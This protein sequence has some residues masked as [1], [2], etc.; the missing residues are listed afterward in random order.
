MLA[1]AA[2]VMLLA[3]PH[4]QSEATIRNAGSPASVVIAI[5][6][7]GSMGYRGPDGTHL[8]AGKAAARRFV[9]D[10]PAGSQVAVITADGAASGPG[11]LYDRKTVVRLIDEVGQSDG[12]V[13]VGQLLR[14]ALALLSGSEMERRMVV[15]VNDRTA[16]SWSDARPAAFARA[17][18]A[19]FYLLDAWSGED[20]NF[21]LGDV[22]LDR[23]STPV[24]VPVSVQTS[25]RC[26]QA[27][28]QVVVQELLGEDVVDQKGVDLPSADAVA[29]MEFTAESDTPGPLAGRLRIDREDPLAMDNV[30][31][32]ALAVGQAARMVVVRSAAG[33]AGDD[34][35]ARTMVSATPVVQAR[36]VDPARFERE[37]LGD[38]AIVLLANVSALPA[39]QWQRLRDYVADGGNLWIV[40]GDVADLAD[41]NSQSAQM[42]LPAPLTGRQS[43]E[44]SVTFRTT[45]LSGAY[46]APFATPDNPSLGAVSFTRRF[47]LGAP[48]D[49]STVQ[50]RFSDDSPAILTRAVGR[51]TVLLWAFSP[52]A[53]YGNLV[54]AEG[55]Q[56]PILAS[57]AAITLTGA[58]AHQHN[59]ELGQ[60]ID[61][62]V[63]REF[64]SAA[65]VVEKPSGEQTPVAIDPVR[66]TIA[67]R[68]DRVGHWRV[69]LNGPAGRQT[70]GLAVNSPA[71]ES[72]LSLLPAEQIEERFA[73]GAV[74]IGQADERGGAVS[75][76]RQSLLDLGPA[77]L[78]AVLVLLIAES[79]LSNRFYRQSGLAGGVL[80]EPTT[81]LRH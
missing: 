39:A 53:A 43:L 28:G 34:Q 46:M 54:S 18:G 67:L 22:L 13:Q 77:L 73:P 6:N 12:R 17:E 52:E 57:Q 42:L 37:S 75:L 44:P 10:L 2:L 49:G 25:I 62:P 58:A 27:A 23:Q 20:R 5:D 15:L 33:A 65:A 14:Q 45:G 78:L 47:E 70:L 63:P 4:L 66:G 55:G 29:A 61:L 19:E 64:R 26:G 11:F 24:G 3:R 41:Y 74:S 48:A 59:F 80:A 81:R 76:R 51:G 69:H 21:A 56:L 35:T 8:A 79:L 7:S 38:V 68:L 32:F 31:Y 60:S 50:T 71:V 40:P 30:R 36:T 16:V 9:A 1:I 72:D